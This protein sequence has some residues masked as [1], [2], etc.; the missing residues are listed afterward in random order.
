MNILLDTHAFLWFDRADAQLSAN[1]K[2][3]IEDPANDKYISPASYW[4]LAIKISV[5]KYA[6]T[7]PYED[8]M[9]RAIDGNG[10][11]ILPVH[12]R[13][14]ARLTNMPFHHRDPFDRLMIAQALVEQMPIVSNDALF[15]PYGVQRLW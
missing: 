10:F 1:A 2:R 14:T 4:E 12:W 5:G 13:H 15:D 3:A 8:F 9:K 6:L 7:E 11:T